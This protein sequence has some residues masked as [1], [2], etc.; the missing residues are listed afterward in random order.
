MTP[1]TLRFEVDY[2]DDGAR[3][4]QFLTGRVSDLT[5]SALRRLI[6]QGHVTIDGVVPGKPGVGLRVGM[7]VHVHIPAPAD[8]AP[9]GESIPLTSVFED[10]HIL[11]I[12]KQAGLVVHPGSGCPDGTLVNALLGNDIQLA[13]AGGTDRPGIVHRLDRDTSGLLIVAKTDPA[14]HAL[15][16]AFAL[17]T[18]RK[19]YLALVWGR[20]K[21]SHGTIERAIGRSRGNATKMSVADT[22]GRARNALSTYRTVRE[23]PGFTLLEVTPH[24]GR[25]HQIR[26]HVQSI[27][28][29]VVGDDRY[30]GRG[31]PGIQLAI[32]RNAVRD[33]KRLALHARRLA[34]EHPITGETLRLEAA[35]PPE[36]QAL[37]DI[38]SEPQ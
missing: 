3:L 7:N 17:R 25:T 12:N 37:I 26:V 10:E 27:G 28:H 9:R 13:P 18:V 30:G 35:V 8:D 31:W 21:A 34:F 20:P 32:K 23:L 11:V 38:L 36:F 29:P 15:R 4:D 2:H 19:Q 5:R 33:F 22:R 16:Q 1:S 24:T 14:Y 6:D